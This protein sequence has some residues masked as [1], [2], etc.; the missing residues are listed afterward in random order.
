MDDSV[1]PR[2]IS[3]LA[4]LAAPRVLALTTG[5]GEIIAQMSAALPPEGAIFAFEPDP[6]RAASVRAR[7]AQAGAPGNVHVMIGAPARLL[8]KVAGPFDLVIATGSPVEAGPV[9]DRIH[10]LLTPL[11]V[12]VSPGVPDD[13]RWDSA[14]LTDGSPLIRSVKR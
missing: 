2:L 1:V 14:A 3:L 10:A 11:G 6:Q 9:L 13:A 4:R 8:H 7:L 12:L 5:D